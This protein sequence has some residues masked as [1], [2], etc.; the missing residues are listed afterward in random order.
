MCPL[1]MADAS[2]SHVAILFVAL[3]FLAACILSVPLA[4]KMIHERM[5]RRLGLE[6][7]KIVP[8]P[9]TLSGLELLREGW[10][11]LVAFEARGVGGGHP[12]HVSVR[13]EFTGRGGLGASPTVPPPEEESIQT[14][15]EAF[16]R[17][18]RVTGNP[19]VARKLLSPDMRERLLALDRMGGQVTELG[20]DALE[21]RGPLLHRPEDLRRF[22]EL[23]DSIVRG[24]MVA[25]QP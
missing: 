17:M 25:V 4:S 19:A 3:G 23:C 20:R 24:A 5:L 14:G 12:G 6:G 7:T 15:D 13:A 10:R 9:W 2:G 1:V 11:C 21:I 8:H 18:I 22:L 16:D